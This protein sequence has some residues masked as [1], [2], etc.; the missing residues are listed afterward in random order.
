MGLSKYDEAWAYNN[1]AVI[2]ERQGK[3]DD[4]ISLLENGE[5]SDPSIKQIKESRDK[6]RLKQPQK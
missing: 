4:A 3:I 6:L 5:K 2:K 1:L